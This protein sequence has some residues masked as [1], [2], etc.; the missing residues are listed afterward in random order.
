MLEEMLESFITELSQ[1]VDLS[2]DPDK[3]NVHY[4]ELPIDNGFDDKQNRFLLFVNTLGV[5]PVCGAY[6]PQAVGFAHEDQL[7]HEQDV[8]CLRCNQLMTIVY[9]KS[10]PFYQNK[11]T[12]IEKQ[13]R[14]L[15]QWQQLLQPENE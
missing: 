9:H 11:L 1:K 7:T 2:V 3:E 13:E 14:T 6:S 12:D 8:R 15:N 4:H 5:C 10:N